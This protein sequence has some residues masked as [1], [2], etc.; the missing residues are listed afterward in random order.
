MEDVWVDAPIVEPQIVMLKPSTSLICNWP[1]WACRYPAYYIHELMYNS[2]YHYA[3]VPEE[4]FISGRDNLDNYDVLILP[5]ATHFPADSN[6]TSMITD[7]YDAGGALIVS[8]IAGGFTE[9]GAFDGQLMDHIIGDVNYT[10]ADTGDL[11]DLIWDVAVSN[12]KADVQDVGTE[13]NSIFYIPGK[14]LMS[15]DI[16]KLKTGGEAESYLYS[17]LDAA[18]PRFVWAEGDDLEVIERKDANGIT[19]VV[20]I[21]PHSGLSRQ[22][23]IHT[24]RKYDYAI[25]R[26]IEGGFAIALSDDA[27]GGHQFDI[28]LAPGEATMV[29]LHSQCDRGYLDSD[30]SGNCRVE[31]SD[32]AVMALDWLKYDCGN[33]TGDISGPAGVPDCYVNFIDIAELSEQWL[34]SNVP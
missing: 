18:A 31:F 17:V 2:N 6:L 11:N 5:F 8:G 32:F 16:D 33:L 29:S 23:T 1:E 30:F 10:R 34:N 3:I 4:H 20:L 24:A 19:H 22:A 25:D 14:F 7:W 27:L 21:N 9:Y 26:G 13:P 28:E 15:A 12:M